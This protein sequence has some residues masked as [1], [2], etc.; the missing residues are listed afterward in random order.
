MSVNFIIRGRLGNAI[1]RYF[2]MSII[3]I[4]TNKSCVIGKRMKYDCTDDIFANMIKNDDFEGPPCNMPHY[5]Q[6]DSIY[7]N[8]MN[9]IKKYIR[10]HVNDHVYTDGVNAGDGKYEKFMMIDILN[11]PLTFNKYYE[12]VLHIRLEDFVTHNLFIPVIKIITLL[13]SIMLP[14]LCIVCKKPNTPFEHDYIQAL[15]DCMLEFNVT[16]ILEHNDI[17]TDF[18]IMKNANLLICSKSTL[19]WTAALLSDNLKTCYFPDY[20]KIY[21]TSC[22]TPIDNTIIY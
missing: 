18:H 15:R 6:H 7:K 11:T 12:N 20:K 22:S 5:Y 4:K 8:N 9:E 13:K 17:L 3:C 21:P 16:I 10:N 14:N 19:S 2:A 1:F